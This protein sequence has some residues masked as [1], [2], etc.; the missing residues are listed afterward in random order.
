M[1]A[2]KPVSFKSQTQ[3]YNPNEYMIVRR[4]NAE[5][6]KQMRKERVKRNIGSSAIWAGVWTAVEAMVSKTKSPSR[7]F[8]SFGLTFGVFTVA[9]LLVNSVFNRRN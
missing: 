5:D 9:S 6:V 1:S 7:L 4:P 3:N 8:K 2:I